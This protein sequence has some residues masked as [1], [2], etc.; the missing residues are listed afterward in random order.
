MTKITNYTL[1]PLAFAL[2]CP[3]I[4]ALESNH[5]FDWS[6]KYF[7][8]MIGSSIANNRSEINYGNDS[9]A[10][11]QGWGQNQFQGNVYNTVESMSPVSSDTINLLNWST[12]LIKTK[13]V[14]KATLLVG[15]ATQKN[16]TVISGEFKSSFGNFGTISTEALTSSG[17]RYGAEF[18][19]NL[20]FTNYGSVLTG[21]TSPHFIGS[22]PGI[23]AVNYQQVSEQQNFIEFR[24][25]NSAVGHLGYSFG[26]VMVYGLAGIAQADVKARTKMTINETA[27]GQIDGT[28]VFTA[29]QDYYF[30]GE[31]TKKLLGYTV[32]TG[33]NWA[34]Q[35]DLILRIEAECYNLG[36]M[37]VTGASL[38]TSATYNAKQKVQGYSLSTGLIVKF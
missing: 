24:N 22:Y 9:G 10:P 2:T 29:E 21:I 37:D 8:G 28:P 36:S 14:H 23:Y 31:K 34:M 30:Y 3:A 12:D 26:R 25:I 4:N 17:N 38:Q 6:G 33:I 20:T 16:N 19:G 1:V 13:H 15:I 11:Q 35:D 32:G 27:S 5:S 18:E 7:G